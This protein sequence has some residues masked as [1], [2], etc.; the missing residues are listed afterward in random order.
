MR[1]HFAKGFTL[2]ELMIVVGIV[3]II[4]AIA[5]PSYTNQVRKSHRAEA[6]NGLGDLQLRQERWR[7]ENPNYATSA[8]LNPLPTSSYYLFSAATPAGNCAPL[9]SPPVT[10]ACSSANCY[11]VTATTTGDQTA[12][13]GICATMTISNKCGVV[14]K[15]STP[16]GGSCW[17]K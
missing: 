1:R 13:N 3:A 15:T 4:A 12:D 10:V 7:S 6:A 9:G 5:I 17:S 14:T 11:S 2:I 8:Q 16:S